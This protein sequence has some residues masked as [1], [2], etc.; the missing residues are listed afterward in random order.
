VGPLRGI[1][2]HRWNAKR[3]KPGLPFRQQKRVSRGQTQKKE[4]AKGRENAGD[5]P[6]IQTF[7]SGTKK[8]QEPLG[9]TMNQATPE[10]PKSHDAPKGSRSFKTEEPRECR[11]K[12]GWKRESEQTRGRNRCGGSKHSGHFARGEAGSKGKYR[13]VEV[14]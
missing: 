12:K 11:G 14:K 2:G 10:R 8:P 1:I 6:G 13:N 5:E 9:Y 4:P 7:G 3:R